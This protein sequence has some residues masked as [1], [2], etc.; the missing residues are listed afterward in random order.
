MTAGKQPHILVA[1]D[2]H[3]YAN[4]YKVKLAKE[5]FAVEVV[6]DGEW[7]IEAAKK[8]KPDLVLL[9]LVMPKA[10]GF[11]VLKALK[12]DKNLASVPVI[13]LTN[14]GKDDDRALATKLGA[15]DYLVKASNSIQ[16]IVET[17]KQYV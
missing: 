7:A 4:I 9:D 10:D 1:E 3:F 16:S 12:K 6:S 15:N 17:I 13:I 11:D 5:G 2:D 14:L 8:H